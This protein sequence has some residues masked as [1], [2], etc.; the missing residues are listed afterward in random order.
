M[1][2]FTAYRL[3]C[4]SHITGLKINLIGELFTFLYQFPENC[5]STAALT[6]GRTPGG[7]HANYGNEGMSIAAEIRPGGHIRAEILNVYGM[8]MPGWEAV[9]GKERSPAFRQNTGLQTK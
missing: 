7:A 5:R 8:V 2:S 3:Y 6:V 9:E 1:T 4:V